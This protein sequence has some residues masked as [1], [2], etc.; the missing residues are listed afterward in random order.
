MKREDQ[1]IEF[2]QLWN[3]NCFKSVCAFANT[4]GG[5]LFVGIDDQGKVTGIKDCAKSLVD[6]PNKIKDVLGITPEVFAKTR[7]GKDTIE[8]KIDYSAAPISFHGHFYIRSGSATSELKGHELSEFLMLKSGRSWDG[9]IEER[10]SLKDIDISTIK[11]FKTLAAKRL[12]FI[13]SEKTPAA[14]LR[15]LNLWNAGGLQGG[16]RIEDLKKEHTSKPRNEFLADVF[17]KAGMIE[18]WGRGTI[19]ILNECE[20]AGLSEPEFREEFGGFSVTLHKGGTEEKAAEKLG[21]RLGEKLGDRLG[22]S[23]RKIL[24]LIAGNKFLSISAMSRA[25]GISTTAIENNLKKLKDKNILKRIGSAKG[26]HWE[27]VR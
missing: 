5:K 24:S 9:F 10:A 3:D 8:I 18:A 16:I 11:R 12:P 21:D 27:A 13:Q 20:K 1:N 23:E 2:K 17:F 26:G 22:E 14:I 6:I 19:K 7:N 25:L 4:R 15:K